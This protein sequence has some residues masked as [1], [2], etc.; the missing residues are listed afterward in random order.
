[1]EAEVTYEVFENIG[2][3]EKIVFWKDDKHGAKKS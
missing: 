1:V 3:N 2:T